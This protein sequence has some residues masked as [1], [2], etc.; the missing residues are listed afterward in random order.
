MH[1]LAQDFEKDS[2]SMSPATS[3][4]QHAA[5]AEAVTERLMRTAIDGVVNYR[6]FNDYENLVYLQDLNGIE[7]G[8]WQ[9]G[10]QAA[11]AMLGCTEEE[12]R[13]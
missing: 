8:D 13:E 10:R 12:W 7:V 3:F 4:G 2:A 5:Y 11:A 9:H 6:A 1:K